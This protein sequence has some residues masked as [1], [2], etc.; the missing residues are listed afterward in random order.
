M[1][2]TESSQT[3]GGPIFAK[4]LS[5]DTIAGKDGLSGRIDG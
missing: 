4:A 3:A 1:A 2:V 5:A